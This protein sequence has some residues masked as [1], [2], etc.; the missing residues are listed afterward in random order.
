MRSDRSPE[1]TWLLRAALRCAVGA[2]ALELEEARAQH[3]HGAP[4]VLMLAISR[5]T[6]H[7]D[8]GRQMRDAHGAV[9]LVDVLPAGAAGPHG[10]DPDVLSLMSISMSSAS[11]STATVA[12]DVWMR[13]ALSVAGTRC[14]R[15]T[16]LSNLSRANTPWPVIE[17]MISL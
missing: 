11:G 10:V 13:P 4:P 16:P 17:A 12:A 3:L 5:P 1:P 15:C 8:P 2:I 6:R 9:R 7:H 14:T